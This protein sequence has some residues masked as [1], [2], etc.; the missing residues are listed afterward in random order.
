MIMVKKIPPLVDGG[1]MKRVDRKD[2]NHK[3]K[4][5]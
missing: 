4:K 1:G 3:M 5:T 2:N